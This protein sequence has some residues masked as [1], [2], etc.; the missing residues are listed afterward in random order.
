MT[1]TDKECALNISAYVYNRRLARIRLPAH[2]KLCQSL[3]RMLLAL[4]CHWSFGRIYTEAD[5]RLA[6]YPTVGAI[7]TWSAFGCTSTAQSFGEH[8][9]CT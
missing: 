5:L 4:P 3:Q 8:R 7:S 6:P 2:D 1:A 9:N